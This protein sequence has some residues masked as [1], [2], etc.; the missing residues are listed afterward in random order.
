MGERMANANRS[1]RGSNLSDLEVYISVIESMPSE[2]RRLS[3]Q[4]CAK[5][6]LIRHLIENNLVEGQLREEECRPSSE[7]CVAENA[8]GVCFLFYVRGSVWDVILSRQEGGK[9]IIE[10][11]PERL[12]DPKLFVMDLRKAAKINLRNADFCR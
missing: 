7:E 10:E 6:I 5:F 4:E 8:D 2:E 9:R 12:K 11:Y 1:E 3:Y